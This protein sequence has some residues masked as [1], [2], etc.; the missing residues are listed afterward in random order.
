MAKVRTRPETGTLYLDFFYRGVRCR[1]QTA[2]EDTAANRR[3][4]QAL[5]N[6]IEKEIRQGTFDYAATFPASPRAARFESSNGALSVP[7]RSMRLPSAHTAANVPLF[8]EFS[9]TWRAEM[10][11]QWRRLHRIAVDVIF[12]RHLLPN[13]GPRPLDQ[14]TKAEVLSFRARLADLPG[15]GNK[16]LSSATINKVMVILR[17]MMAEAAD[18]FDLPDAFKGI[19][20]LKGKKSEVQPFAMDEVE[21]I[22]TTIR[23]DYRNYITVRFF[24]GMRT[25][26]IN[27]LKWKNVDFERGLILVREVFSAGELEENA[28]TETSLRD[29]PMLPIVREALDAQWS[30]RHPDS[31][32]VFCSR[33]GAPIDAHNFANRIWYPLLRYLDVEKRR[34]YQTR[35]TTATLML[36]AGENPEWIA[37]LMGHANTQMLFTV[38]SRFVPNL[39]RQDGLAITGF[40]NSRSQSQ[41]EAATP[42]TPEQVSAMSAKELRA[43]LRQLLA[44]PSN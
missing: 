8:G 11:P 9:A 23:A 36:A 39:T 2:L 41:T 5:L 14:I 10:A 38:Y 16:T 15:R 18:R 34:P 19:K 17:Q 26:E 13:F 32:F 12:D 42:I 30:T 6:R 27:G 43:A 22:R 29:I 4:V 31:E 24:T 33:D 44:T 21:R 40:L 7:A 3:S 35:H 25:G 28:K 37:K 1:E 20:R